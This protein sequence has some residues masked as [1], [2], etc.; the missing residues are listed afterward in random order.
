MRKSILIPESEWSKSWCSI[1]R[2]IRKCYKRNK[3][4]EKWSIFTVW[5]KKKKSVP[6]ERPLFVY[7]LPNVIHRIF[8]DSA[9]CLWRWPLSSMCINEFRF[10]ADALHK[11]NIYSFTYFS[12]V[13]VASILNISNVLSWHIKKKKKKKRICISTKFIGWSWIHPEHSYITHINRYIKYL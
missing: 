1:Y 6:L 7:S 2:R 12:V 3:T 9:N 5:K 11:M 10:L 13:V 4:T 8:I